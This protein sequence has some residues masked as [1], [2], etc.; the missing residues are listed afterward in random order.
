VRIVSYRGSRVSGTVSLGTFPDLGIA[1]AA[2]A[3]VADAT[4]VHPYARRVATTHTF[5]AGLTPPETWQGNPR[6]RGR[7][8]WK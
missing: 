2:A 6:T 1:I 8:S 4:G 5:S 3:K 7:P